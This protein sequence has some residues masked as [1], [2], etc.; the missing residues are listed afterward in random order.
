MQK[1][2]QGTKRKLHASV[3]ALA[4][5]AA[6]GAFAATAQALPLG[7]WG[8]VPQSGLTSEQFQRLSQGGVESVRVGLNWGSVQPSRG[9]EYEWDGFD[10]QL[11]AAAQAGI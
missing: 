5:V 11:E 9:G 6:L 2:G 10:T 8:V 3:A 7:F 1:R 4:V